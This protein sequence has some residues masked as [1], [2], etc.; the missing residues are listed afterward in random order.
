M[1]DA[2]QRRRHAR[3][4]RVRR[5]RLDRPAEFTWSIRLGDDP[6]VVGMIGAIFAPPMVTLG[7]VLARR[8]WGQGIMSEA[9]AVVIDAMFECDDVHRV[10]AYCAL[11]NPGSARVMQKAGMRY[12]G[13]LRSYA[14][15]STGDVV[16]VEAYARVRRD[17]SG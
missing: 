14:R 3:V 1:V 15:L 12:E 5:R 17:L 6:L 13:V 7:Y 10:W 2:P 4:P 11:S 8:L 9:A 16:D